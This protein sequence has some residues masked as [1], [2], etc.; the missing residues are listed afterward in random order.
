MSEG[1]K[2]N[3]IEVELTKP[4]SVLRETLERIGIANRK[5]KKIFPSCYAKKMD[6]SKVAIF[7]FKELLKKPVLDVDDIKRKNTIIWLLIKWNLIKISDE[8][9]RQD[10]ASNMLQKKIFILPKKQKDDEKWEIV[11]KFHFEGRN[12]VKTEGGI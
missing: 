1:I 11:H 3:V 12:L 9:V 5:E 2:V 7:H 4:F 10:I 6:G 8:K